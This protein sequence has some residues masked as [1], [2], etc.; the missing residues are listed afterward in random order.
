[1]EFKIYDKNDIKEKLQTK[2]LYMACFP[3]DD[4][5]YLDYYYSVL[6][7]R[8][9]VCV[10]EEDNKIISMLH[11]NPYEYNVCGDITN[12]HYIYAIATDENYRNKGYM[13]K[14]LQFAISYLKTLNEPFC[15]LAPEKPELESMYNKLGFYKICNYTFDKFS[16]DKYDIYPVRNDEFNTLIK[17][18][19]ELLEEETEEYIEALKK[20]VILAYPLIDKYSIEYLRTKKIYICN[21]A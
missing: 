14:L 8:N 2:Q 3:Y 7:K 4:E 6:I 15:Y 20:R 17:K 9:V 5:E 21:E 16:N 1:M 13:K 19:Q 11:L 12:V 10:I 18:E